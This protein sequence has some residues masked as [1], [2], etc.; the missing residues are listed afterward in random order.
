MSNTLKSFLKI[1]LESLVRGIIIA[2][3]LILAERMGW[4]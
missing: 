3:L 2:L 1:T 4:L